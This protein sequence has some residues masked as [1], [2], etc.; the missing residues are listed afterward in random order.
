M[1]KLERHIH[2]CIIARHYPPESSGG[3]RRPYLFT[4]ALRSAGHRVTV[5]SPFAL[6]HP[7]HIVVPHMVTDRYRETAD[8]ET[9]TVGSLDYSRHSPIRNLARNWLLWPDPEIRWARRAVTQLE[10]ADL[11]VD[12]VITTSPPESLHIV[13]PMLKTAL[14]CRWIA[15][16]R[17]T[18]TLAPHRAVLAQSALR[19]GV[20][21]R[22]AR[23]CLRGVDA[24][25]GV[26]DAVL[27]EIRNYT[28]P[29][30]PE[31]IIGHFSDAP[32]APV[33]LPE[34]DLNIVHSGGFILSDRNRKLETALSVLDEVSQ[35]R[36]DRRIHL[37]IAGELSPMER[38]MLETRSNDDPSM[39][40]VTMHGQV[41]LPRSRGLQAGADA[42]LLHTPEN[43]HALP[44]KYAEYR[45]TN[46]PIL[47]LGGGDWLS[48]VDAPD[49]L[50]PLREGLASLKKGARAPA[51]C[52]PGFSAAAATDEL[53][54][55]LMTL[56]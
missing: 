29:G 39:A 32:P 2:I 20:E 25:T 11:S 53:V 1:T 50:L 8:P 54:Q 49:S 6:D 48:L 55:F 30:T 40:R 14:D 27:S 7:D 22:L 45:Q 5:V 18:W 16:F 24:V 47:Y 44:G 4:N 15:E 51:S 28:P 43:S 23:R 35:Q 3:A 21:R 52:P 19:R 56:S 13:G 34:Y 9:V 26:S 42:L 36:R 41:S 37:H 46:L 10:T 38:Q 12:W 31:H 17:D 33:Q